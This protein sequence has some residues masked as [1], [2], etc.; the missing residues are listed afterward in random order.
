MK[1]IIIIFLII[2]NIIN[3]PFGGDESLPTI[4][5]IC[6]SANINYKRVQTA[7]SVQEFLDKI[8]YNLEEER[9][10]STNSFLEKLFTQDDLTRETNPSEK[11]LFKLT[12]KYI[13]N[14]GVLS[15]S[16][17][18][19]GLIISL[20]L[21]KCF[22]S[23]GSPT[24]KLFAK[25]YI[26]WGQIIFFIIFILSCIPF[27]SSWKF[28]RSFQSASCSLVRFLQEVKFGNST[29]NEGRI[30]PK[31]YTWLGLLNIDNILLDIQNFFNK[32]GN[33]RR[34]VFND[35]DIIKQNISDFGN[36]INSL[37]NF[38]KNSSILFYNRKMFPLYIKEFDDINK[39]GS[40][41]NIIYNQYQF[42]LERNFKNMLNIN[43]TTTIFEERNL[44]YKENM[45]DVYNQTNGYSKLISQKSINITHNIQFLHE[46]TFNFIFRYIR[47]SYIFNILISFFLSIFIFIY[48]RKRNY[49]FK[50]ILHFGW[51]ICMIIILTSFVLS[52]FILSLGGSIYH[53]IYVI[54]NQV[55]KVD[56]NN[57]FNIC[58]NKKGNLLELMKLEQVRNFAE[59]NDFYHLIKRQTVLIKE[60]SHNNT[61]KNYINEIKKLKVDISLTTDEG[62]NFIDINHLLKRLSEITGDKWVSE[63]IACKKYR[64]LGKNIMLDLKRE[65]KSEM[66]Y[67]LTIQD[68]YNEEELKKIYNDKDQDKIYE[69]ITIVNNLNSYYQQ[70]E[71]ILTK[72]EGFL[73]ELDKTHYDL[74]KEVNK[75]TDDIHDLVNL[76]LSLFPY[77]TEE[78]SLSDLL[79]CEILKG[80]LIAYYDFNYNYVYFYCKLFGFISLAVGLLTFIGMILIINSIQ[81][82]D[83]EEFLKNKDK[84]NNNNDEEEELDEIIEETGEE[85]DE[86]E[87]EKKT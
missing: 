28:K 27:F 79:N 4:R 35:I 48:Y 22:F 75:K 32:T 52:Y 33:N 59:L 34:E 5:K 7:D 46:K 20:I 12:D 82:I 2:E 58:L 56:Q 36:K 87:D 73:T 29:Y 21:G 64:Y 8:D 9:N 57:F 55:L 43:D 42:P 71:E 23:E 70:N 3:Q 62:Y 18:W 72:L 39:K 19:I 16:I 65:N 30:F 53:L 15:L 80:E 77:M 54:H 66:D 44:V 67:C 84:Y 85:Y 86:D 51:N 60:I 63:R 47:Y 11:Y 69:I 17:F 24:K 74:I 25:K 61:I 14:K 10:K 49:C 1:K 38:I 31:P 26:N 40:K 76:Y 83:N 6:K 41:I 13:F 45:E 78:E 37:M 81:W 68:N 50:L